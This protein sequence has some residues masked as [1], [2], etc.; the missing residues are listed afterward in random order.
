MILCGPCHTKYEIEAMKLK[1]ELAKKYDAPVNGKG[2]YHDGQLGQ[3]KK[4][5]K[6][7]LTCSAVMPAPRIAELQ[8]LIR[9]HFNYPDTHVLTQEDLLAA[10]EIEPLIKTANYLSH[11]QAVV[12]CLST[13][14]LLTDFIQMWRKHFVDTMQPQYLHPLWLI[15]RGKSEF[16]SV[17][18]QRPTP[19]PDS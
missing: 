6:A 4:A 3:V 2:W 11:G 19:P 17:V 15:D 9:N 5:G 12:S 13:P 7:L 14:D 16:R 18:K 1:N 8:S 10:S